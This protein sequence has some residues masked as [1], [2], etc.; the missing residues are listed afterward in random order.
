M[1]P[2]VNNPSKRFNSEVS[3]SKYLVLVVVIAGVTLRGWNIVIDVKLFDLINMSP[4]YGVGYV[5]D[6]VMLTPAG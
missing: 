5:C 2:I 6:I 3:I 4:V 1:T